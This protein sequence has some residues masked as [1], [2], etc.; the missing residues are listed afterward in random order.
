MRFCLYCLALVALSFLL[1]SCSSINSRDCSK[2][3]YDFGHSQGM[4]GSPKKLTN[5][6]RSKCS[7]LVPNIDIESYEKGFMQ[8]WREY[9]L[10]NHAFDLGK[11][12]DVYVSFCP[13]ESEQYF[14]NSY[15]LGKKHYEL[16]DLEGDLEERLSELKESAK[17]N[18]ESYSEL[19]R[20]QNELEHIKKEIQAVEVEGRKNIFNFH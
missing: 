1:N 10:P 4:I 17:D 2:N 6:I 20:I 11:K 7:S 19:N 13:N 12:S 18:S 16:K 14:R 3:M 5:Q 9:C 8:G 15:L